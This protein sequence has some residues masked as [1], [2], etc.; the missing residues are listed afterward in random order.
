MP[1]EI[2]PITIVRDARG[3]TTTISQSMGIDAMD[4][5]NNDFTTFEK[6]NKPAKVNAISMGKIDP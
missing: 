2:F 6:A 1:S 4:G 5:R 3:A